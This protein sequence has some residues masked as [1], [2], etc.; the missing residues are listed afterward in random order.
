MSSNIV[1]RY[2][3]TITQIYDSVASAYRANETELEQA[4]GEINDLLHEIEL[5]KPKNAREGYVIYKELREARQRRRKAKDENELLNELYTYLQSQ[6]AFK[7]RI[8][9]I[10]GNAR[11]LYTKQQGRVYTPRKRD[12]MTISGHVEPEAKPFEEMMQ[13][14]KKIKISSQGG[15]LRK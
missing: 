5:G 3:T 6:A 2:A 4:N 7:N 8:T 11:K 1:D 15:K 14:F 12:D 13:D 10:Q 9:Q